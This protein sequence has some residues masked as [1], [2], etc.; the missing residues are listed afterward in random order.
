MSESPLGVSRWRGFFVSLFKTECFC[1]GVKW[2]VGSEYNRQI[3]R[4]KPECTQNAMGGLQKENLKRNKIKKNFF[5]KSGS[6]LISL[7]T[8]ISKSSWTLQNQILVLE[9]LASAFRQRNK[10]HPNW[11][12]RSQTFTLH[13]GRDTLH[14]KPKS[15]HQKTVR[16]ARGIQESRRI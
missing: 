9:D 1:Y 8:R 4:T 5:S 6:V 12:K 3:W 7:F 14:G 11:H 13:R 2:H 15:F 16:A 10:R